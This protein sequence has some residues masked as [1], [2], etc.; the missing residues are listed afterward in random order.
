MH[1]LLLFIHNSILYLTDT[2][3]NVLYLQ[4]FLMMGPGGSS[5]GP[6]PAQGSGRPQQPRAEDPSR[7][8]LAKSRDLIPLL[9]EKERISFSDDLDFVI[10]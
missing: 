6:P 3:D 9:R 2:F 4:I 1:K 7:Q 10:G 8:I 5:Q